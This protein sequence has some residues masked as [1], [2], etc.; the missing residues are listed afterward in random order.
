[1]SERRPWVGDLIHDVDADRRGI[2]TDVRDGALW[3]LR[4]E[5]GPGQWTSEVPERLTVVRS[6]HQMREPF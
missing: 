6:R 3:V 5:S 1:M 4:A 2:V